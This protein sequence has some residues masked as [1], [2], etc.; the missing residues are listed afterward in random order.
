VQD[1]PDAPLAEYLEQISLASDG[2]DNSVDAAITLMTIHSAK[3]LEFDRVI[4]TGLEEEVFPHIRVLD[5]NDPAALEEER[6][7]AYVAL[8]RAR[9][10]LT[11]SYVQSRFLWGRTLDNEPSRYL[12]L[13][14]EHAITRHGRATVR[15][16]KSAAPAPKPRAPAWDDDIE[17][18]PEY[19]GSTTI[20]R[21]TS[22]GESHVEY[23]DDDHDDDGVSVFKGMQVRHPKWGVG[24]VLG[25]TGIGSNLKL[26]L[27]FAGE[28]RVVL[29][30]FC[31]LL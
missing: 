19:A 1:Q 13:L 11:L 20:G 29:A 15:K 5:D 18:E 26:T 8:T 28:R 12:A 24:T 14:P 31:Q 17:L 2:D 21:T 23:D 10:K 3:G 30:R 6:R 4:L 9:R 16:P 22:A 7:L 27:S 25:W